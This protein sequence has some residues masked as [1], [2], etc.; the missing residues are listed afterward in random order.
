MRFVPFVAARLARSPCLISWPTIASLL[1]DSALLSVL[2]KK[3]VRLLGG[4]HPFELSEAARQ[5]HESWPLLNTRSPRD[6][7]W[8]IIKCDTITSL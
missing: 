5:Y 7:L 8:L 1:F 6:C 2:R 4:K 3:T